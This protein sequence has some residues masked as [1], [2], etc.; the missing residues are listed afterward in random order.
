M[1]FL[2]FF[3]L[4]CLF[5]TSCNDGIKPEGKVTDNSTLS[6]QDSIAYL[7][8]EITRNS[9]DYHLYKDRARLFL[10][11]GKIDPALRD[12]NSAIE[13]NQDDPE[14][15][16]LLGDIYFI[17][18]QTDNSLN[19][20]KKAYSINPENVVPLLSLAE[21]YLV[22]QD[23][24]VSE[25]YLD[26]ASSVDVNQAKTFYLKGILE[27]E[28]GDTLS[29]LTNLKIAGNIDTLY[30]D[31]FMQTGSLLSS[32]KDTTAV[33]FYQKALTAKPGDE[34]A[35]FLTAL[36]Y[37][38]KGNVD[39]A[40]DLYEELITI[41]PDNK[42]ALYNCGYLYMV[43][44]EDFEQAITYYRQAIVVDPGFVSAVYNLGR[45]YEATGR[46]E[47]A[48]LQYRQALELETNYSLA[49]DGLNRLDKIQFDD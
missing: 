16:I 33:D 27:M 46:Y 25:K 26:L 28:T 43:E 31:A 48:R 29:A 49:I 7:S 15:F 18:G 47:E 13:L 6:I 14:I 22:L 44:L 12:I 32:L 5:V 45:T 19:S 24:E 35:M 42:N 38:E 11:S 1:R 2:V 23:Y 20:Y 3:V 30:F 41:Y 37:Q 10:E 4:V 36:A 39:A 9:S 17:L 34:R 21:A 8:E 40:L